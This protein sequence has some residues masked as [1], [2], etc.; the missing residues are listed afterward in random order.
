MK[1]CKDF[2]L[3]QSI[4]TTLSITMSRSLV[5]KME[6]VEDL[7]YTWWHHFCGSLNFSIARWTGA[8]KSSLEIVTTSTRRPTSSESTTRSLTSLKRPYL[9]TITRTTQRLLM[10]WNSGRMWVRARVTCNNKLSLSKRLSHLCL[11]RCKIKLKLRREKP[12]P[13]PPL[14]SWSSQRFLMRLMKPRSSRGQTWSNFWHKR[15]QQIEMVQ[16][17]NNLWRSQR[18]NLGHTQPN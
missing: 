5:S 14:R 18:C 13:L 9:R 7:L 4:K 8:P 2:R 10:F 15:G 17:S 6:L 1:T 11:R 3:K 12:A 16:S